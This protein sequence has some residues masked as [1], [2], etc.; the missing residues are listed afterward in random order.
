[1]TAWS[2]RLKTFPCRED[3]REFILRLPNDTFP[4]TGA[5]NAALAG[6]VRNA[7]GIPIRFVP[8]E[9]IPGVPYEQHIFDS[10]EV[11]T[12]AANWHD[13]FNAMVWMRFPALKS[14]MNAA[15][16]S[17][18]A[19]SGGDG[20]G[21][22]RDALTLFDECGV[23]LVSAHESNL[24]AV[25]RHD[26]RRVFAGDETSWAQRY[27]VFI[28]GHALLEKMLKPYK[29]MTAHALLLKVSE[30]AFR[31]SRE[32]MIREIDTWFAAA[33]LDGKVLSATTAL[34]PLPLMGIPGWW[35]ESPQDQAFYD[36]GQVFRA[37]RPERPPAPVHG[38]D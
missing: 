23:V 9:S 32:D 21:S 20:R 1:M 34:S 18:M 24:E 36:D 13:L 31:R 16:H 19:H 6:R 28:T 37:A 8:A 38:L 14:S 27:R 26:W 11:S 35:Q 33:L 5:L 25:A 17:A 15:H 29:A 4:E 2:E 22:L 7:S 30:D 12:R 10:G 3:Y